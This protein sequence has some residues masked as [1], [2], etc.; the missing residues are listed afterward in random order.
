MNSNIDISYLPDE[1]QKQIVNYVNFIAN[2]YK[3][4]QNEF[5]QDKQQRINKLKS[6]ASKIY[7]LSID[8]PVKWQ[9]ETRIDKQLP[10]RN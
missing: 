9:I 1:A 6:L 7:F 4:K 3:I 10:N 2:E 8:E 5:Y